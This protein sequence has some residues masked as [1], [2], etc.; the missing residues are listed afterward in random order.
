MNVRTNTAQVRKAV[1]SNV[2]LIL[3]NHNRECL[4]CKRN[5]SCELQKLCDELG[6]TEVSYEGKMRKAVVDDLSHSIVL[7]PANISSA[8]DASAS[9][10]TA[11]ASAFSTS[12]T[13]GSTPKLL[14]LLI[15]A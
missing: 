11:R 14:L 13:E 5:G 9:A 8:A 12:H 15:S 1:K 4:V 7:I 10:E 3:A 6:L 2:E